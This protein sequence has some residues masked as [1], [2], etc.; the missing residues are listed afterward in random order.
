M[1]KLARIIKI[2]ILAA[3][4]AAAAVLLW[5][6]LSGLICTLLV[7]AIAAYLL[8]KPTRAMEK[9]MKRPWALLIL[10]GSL[11]GAT[12]FIIYYFIP[13]FFRQAAD[14]IAY[15][16]KVLQGAGT[17]LNNFGATAGEPLAGIIDQAFKGLNGRVAVWL[18]GATIAAA[19]SCSAG[20]GWAIL[21]PFFTFYFLKDH[22]Y[23]TDQFA[24]LV[25]IRWRSDAHALYV[26]IDKAIAQFLRGQLLVSLTVAVLV[27][28]GLLV[29]GVPNA[30][31]LG[32]ICGLCNMIPYIGP[33]IG[34][35]PVAL[36]SAVLGW[37]TMLLALLVVFVV[38]QLDNMII[39]PKIIGDSIRIHPAYIIVAII[40]GSGLFGVL[41]LV[42]ALPALIIFKEIV[43]FIFRKTLHRKKEPT[44]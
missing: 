1:D 31:L 36:V 39:S 43:T 21:F 34:I 15:I 13:L 20:V 22:E 41:G 24:Y 25:P 9:K 18:G 19:Q 35:V 32:L 16:P 3:V 37:K 11:A 40:A 4:C 5:W 23:F 42:F 8:N 12:A 14:L 33:F 30:L 17:L 28:I 44:I 38:Q 10:F 7:S 27:T 26:S 29:V 6:K 2:V